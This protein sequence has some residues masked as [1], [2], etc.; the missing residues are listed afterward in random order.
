MSAPSFL[1]VLRTTVAQFQAAH[2]ERE[3][4]L[5]RAH[6]LILQGMVLPTDD[7]A[8]ARVL[9]SDGA[10]IYTVNGSCDCS[11]GQHG[12]ACK[13]MHAWKLYQHILKKQAPAPVVPDVIEPWPDNDPEEA[14]E[15]PPVPL[16]E[17][18][19]SVNVRVTIAG[20]EVQWTLRDTDEA[21]LARRLEALLQRYPLQGPPQPPVSQGKDFCKVHQVVMK[22]HTNDKGSWFSHFVDGRHCKGK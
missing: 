22:E 18:P 21:R 4:E 11:A 13:H 20:R 9:S 1:Q 3:S 16:P 15:P 12:K 2:P 5:A 8:T 10:K 14:P 19:A 7:P 6:A 17:A